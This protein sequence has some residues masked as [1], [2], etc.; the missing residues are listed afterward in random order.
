MPRLCFADGMDEAEDSHGATADCRGFD[1]LLNMNNT[2]GELEAEE[3]FVSG[4]LISGSCGA[5]PPSAVV[6]VRAP[7]WSVDRCCTETFYRR[8][9]ASTPA[10]GISL[11]G[12]AAGASVPWRG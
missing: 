10:G 3:E 9:V 8:G 4:L 1:A 11:R 6:Q 7:L 5:W 12:T 2:V